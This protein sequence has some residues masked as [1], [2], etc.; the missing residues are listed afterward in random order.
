MATIMT[1]IHAQENL[2]HTLR[3]RDSPRYFAEAK[4]L[5]DMRNEAGLCRRCETATWP[6]TDGLCGLCR[7][8]VKT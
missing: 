2:V 7:E 6:T 8:I 4:R 5:G 1:T 3:L